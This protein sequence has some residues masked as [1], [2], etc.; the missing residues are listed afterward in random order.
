MMDHQPINHIVQQMRHTH[1]RTH[2]HT[3][4]HTHNHDA[5]ARFIDVA[6]EDNRVKVA[7][8][9]VIKRL[10]ANVSIASV[11]WVIYLLISYSWDF[12]HRINH[13]FTPPSISFP[14]YLQVVWTFSSTPT[15]NWATMPTSNNAAVYALQGLPVFHNVRECS[16]IF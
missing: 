6:I 15:N 12:R 1:A 3:H 13:L 8:S 4:T 2:T 11:Q 5:A 10:F 7:L 14:T 16:T 9:H